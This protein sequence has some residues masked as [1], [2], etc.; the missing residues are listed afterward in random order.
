MTGGGTACPASQDAATS[1]AAASMAASDPL[2]RSARETAVLFQRAKRPVEGL[3]NEIAHGEG[4]ED[5]R[6]LPALG[7]P[8]AEPV[9]PYESERIAQEHAKRA[10][11]LGALEGGFDHRVVGSDG[12][13]VRRDLRAQPVV[14]AV[15]RGHCLWQATGARRAAPSAGRS[16]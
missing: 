7:R 15:R 5:Q 9:A 14:P 10:R 16:R 11:R 8:P 2:L 6:I 4:I 13:V 12:A 3:V 1:V